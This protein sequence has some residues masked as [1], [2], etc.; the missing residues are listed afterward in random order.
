MMAL[1]LNR[2]SGSRPSFAT[3][4]LANEA[5]ALT[6]SLPCPSAIAPRAQ[7]IEVIPPQTVTA[8]KKSIATVPQLEIV[9]THSYK[10]RKHFLTGTKSGS[11]FAPGTR[12]QLPET[13]KINRQPEKLESPVSYRKQRTG[14]RINR[15]L[16]L[17]SSSKISRNLVSHLKGFTSHKS[18]VTDRGSNV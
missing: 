12:F 10:R 13:A 5:R 2:E 4:G 15:Q 8:N 14:T 3:V 1:D 17:V 6:A 7:F 9:V 18:R 11:S 16:S